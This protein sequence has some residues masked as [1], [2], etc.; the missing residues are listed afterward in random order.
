MPTCTWCHENE[1]APERIDPIGEPWCERCA[2]AEEAAQA[3][4]R[5][6]LE[7]ERVE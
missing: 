1:A 3:K 2:D 5:A 6:E 7:A 4:K